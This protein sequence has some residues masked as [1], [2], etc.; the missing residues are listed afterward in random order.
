MVTI[1]YGVKRKSLKVL[2]EELINN[3]MGPLLKSKNMFFIFSVVLRRSQ[4]E[5]L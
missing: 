4:K 5:I 2:D 3:D 1:K